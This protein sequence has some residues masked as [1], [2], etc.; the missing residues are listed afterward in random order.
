LE[1]DIE[2]TVFYAKVGGIAVVGGFL[3]YGVY[4]IVS[5][6]A[7]AAKTLVQDTPA[8]VADSQG[9]YSGGLVEK[10]I[11]NSASIGKSSLSYTDAFSQAVLHPWDTAKSIA[12]LD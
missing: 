10:A 3:L 1:F 6:V 5:G 4:K 8:S 12:G 11:N 9:N 2:K 7:D